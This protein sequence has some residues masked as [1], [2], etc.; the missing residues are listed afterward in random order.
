M[1]ILKQLFF[2]ISVNGGFGNIFQRAKELQNLFT[3]IRPLFGYIKVLFHI[4]YFYLGKKNANSPPGRFSLALEVERTS[5][6]AGLAFMVL[7]CFY[8]SN[9]S[10]SGAPSDF[11]L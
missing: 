6:V 7:S 1:Y 8:K 2:S 5:L 3:I 10:C 11:F 4:F 9:F